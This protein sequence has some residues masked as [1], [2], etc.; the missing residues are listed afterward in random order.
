MS[1]GAVV[2]TE[3]VFIILTQQNALCIIAVTWLTAF[4]E[5]LL[6]HYSHTT[7]IARLIEG[8]HL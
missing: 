6:G 2:T 7:A 1:C 4:D 3:C 8:V 5:D